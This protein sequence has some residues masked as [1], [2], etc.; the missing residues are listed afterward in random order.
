MSR[1]REGLLRC[2]RVGVPLAMVLLLFWAQVRYY[3]SPFYPLPGTLVTFAVSS[4]S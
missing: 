3:P 4:L 1:A 2:C